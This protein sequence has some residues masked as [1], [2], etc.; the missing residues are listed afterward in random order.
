MLGIATEA[1]LVEAAL[2]PAPR[3]RIT[4]VLAG[5]LCALWSAFQKVIAQVVFYGSGVLGLY[6][7]ALVR[8]RE[9]LALPRDTGWWALGALLLLI[10]LIG[11]TAGWVGRGVGAEALRRLTLEGATPHDG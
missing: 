3:S 2:L 9:W 1:A 8:A 4:A 10:V 11:G 7:A 5:T 6:L